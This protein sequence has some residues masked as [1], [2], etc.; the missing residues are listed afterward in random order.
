MT[1]RDSFR[2]AA[3][4][5]E[6][7]ERI[8]EAVPS[9]GYRE[10]MPGLLLGRASEPTENLH[11]VV[12]P[13]FCLIAQGAKEVYLGDTVYRYDAERYLIATVE[14]PITARVVIASPNEPYLSLR[15]D[16]DPA[17]ISSVMI[18]AGQLP[19]T[20][21]GG[22]K[23]IAVSALDAGVLDATLR[24]MRLVGSPEDARVLSPTVRREIT[25]RLMQGEQGDRLRQLPLSGSQMNRIARAVQRLRRE[26]DKPL[27]IEALAKE[28]GM[29]TSGLHH[30][31]KAVTDMSPLQ[32]QKQLRL[33]EA[34]RLL[35]SED[36]NIATAGY[37]VGYDDPSHFSRD[38]KKLFGTSPVRDVEKL[39]QVVA[40]D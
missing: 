26:Y 27:I 5:E 1:D 31:F 6:L 28:L 16:L 3:N 36:M 22:A 34:R 35:L 8:A 24:L 15:L 18:E 10:P 17:L 13:S 40:P 30:H 23:A 9:D 7:I 12:R 33:Q 37:K 39:R 21:G 20:S 11:G 14:M 25:F 2:N 29:S 38:Y 32:F 19:P 4:R